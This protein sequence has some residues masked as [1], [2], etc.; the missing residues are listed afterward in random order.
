MSELRSRTIWDM[1]FVGLVEGIQREYLRT[2]CQLAT[3]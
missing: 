3:Y 1:Q 2:V